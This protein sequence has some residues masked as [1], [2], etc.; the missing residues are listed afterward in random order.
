MNYFSNGLL[1]YHK[2]RLITRYKHPLGQLISMHFH[3]YKGHYNFVRLLGY[4][5]LPDHIPVNTFKTVFISPL[6]NSFIQ[7]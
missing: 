2:N 3:R 4:I 6:S 1:I 7:S 5:E